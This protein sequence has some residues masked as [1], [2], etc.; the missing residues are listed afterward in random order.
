MNPGSRASQNKSWK[1]C[2]KSFA[3][4]SLIWRELR[5][6]FRSAATTPEMLNKSGP[7][8][9]GK[10]VFPVSLTSGFCQDL[11]T[12]FSAAT[13]KVALRRCMR[14]QK[15]SAPYR[16][17]NRT[18][19]TRISNPRSTSNLSEITIEFFPLLCQNEITMGN[20]YCQV[21]ATNGRIE[22]QKLG[23]LP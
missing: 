13:L 5:F 16:A 22:R 2:R 19:D 6:W 9:N 3:H 23:N 18:D 15:V 17:T 21:D 1:T 10:I 4:T 8:R 11:T 12:A 14:S 20:E 7:A